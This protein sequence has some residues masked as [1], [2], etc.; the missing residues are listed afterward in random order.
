MTDFSQI[1]QRL[2][3][4]P[5]SDRAKE[6]VKKSLT[7]DSLYSGTWP[8][9]WSPGAPEFH[10]IMDELKAAG[11]KM[12]AACPQSDKPGTTFLDAIKSLEGW[13]K[14]LNERPESYKIVRT[15]RDIDEAVAAGKLAIFFT[16]QGSKPFEEDLDRVA[17]F[18]E[19]GYAYCLLAYNLRNSVGDGCVEPENAGLTSFGKMLVDAYNRYGMILDVTHVGERTS[20]DVCE[21]SNAPVISSHSGAYSVF[22]YPRNISDERIKAIAATGGVCAMNMVGAFLDPSNPD[23]VTT[24]ILFQH[25]DHMVNLVGIDYV[26]FGSDYIPDIT[27]TAQIF[28]TPLGDLGFPDGGVIK[29]AAAKGIPSANPA[30]IVAALVDKLLENGYSEEDC[31]KFLGGN[32]YRVFDQVWH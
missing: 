26:G 16:H 27:K 30:R 17:V 8:E 31:G 12:I 3:E 10:D 1:P 22:A 2:H 28:Q 32:L 6:I 25:I 24:D 21:R 15:T 29:A 11:F 20:L 9:Q 19:L 5:A 4:Y 14:K 13:L 18:R 23:I 7:T